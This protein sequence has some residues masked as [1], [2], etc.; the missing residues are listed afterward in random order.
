MNKYSLQDF[1]TYFG[2]S[3]ILDNEGEVQYIIEPSERE[4]SV[5]VRRKHGNKNVDK[6][7]LLDSMEWKRN[8]PIVTCGY[9]DLD[10]T[11]KSLYYI[12]RRVERVTRK[13]ISSHTVRILR[14]PYVVDAMAELGLNVSKYIE[15]A[16][17]SQKLADAI[18][19]PHF[20]PFREAVDELQSK[21]DAVGY[22]LSHDLALCLGNNTDTSLVILFQQIP[23]AYSADGRTWKFYAE[24]HRDVIIRQLGKVL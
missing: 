14:E 17:L 3:Y 1:W 13:G 9:R 23:A 5:K 10:P 7:M 2:D 16:R 22:A 21:A 20:K 6:T 12:V 24:E 11:G 15:D 18:Y 19:K 4:Q 8:T